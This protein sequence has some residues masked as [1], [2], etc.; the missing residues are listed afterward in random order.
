[1]MQV[2]HSLEGAGAQLHHSRFHETGDRSVWLVAG[3]S[4]VDGEIP[5][6]LRNADLEL[7]LVST[8][9]AVVNGASLSEVEK[10]EEVLATRSTQIRGRS[11]SA[12]TW[13][14]VVARADEARAVKALHAL[15]CEEG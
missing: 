6:N 15:W 3:M 11:L 10:A 1:M 12:S 9:S 8:V 4:G 13:T 7:D 2:Y 5:S 14:W